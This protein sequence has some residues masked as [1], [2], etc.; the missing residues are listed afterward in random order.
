VKYKILEAQVFNLA[1]R[2]RAK[3]KPKP[4]KTIPRDVLATIPKMERG[5]L[6]KQV[7]AV[8]GWNTDR[9]CA[10]KGPRKTWRSTKQYARELEQRIGAEGL[11]GTDKGSACFKDEFCERL[12]LKGKK[13]PV[14]AALG[15]DG[16]GWKKAVRIG[17]GSKTR[18]FSDL[19]IRPQWR[20]VVEALKECEGLNLNSAEA[21]AVR[22]HQETIDQ[23][24]E[25][26]A[27]HKDR[28]VMKA[29][30]PKPPKARKRREKVPF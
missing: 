6:K 2:P 21:D 20:T 5:Q 9:A 24:R 17:L 25:N 26:H 19:E 4:K 7:R 14:S 29:R 12:E 28:L 23:C 1:S 27:E 22:L 3:T 11:D 15:G 8:G 13:C 30:E 10:I 18:R 16:G